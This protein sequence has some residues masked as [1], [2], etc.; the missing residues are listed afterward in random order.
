MNKQHGDNP[1][2]AIIAADRT[3]HAK[4]TGEHLRSASKREPTGWGKAKGTPLQLEHNCV[5][6]RIPLDCV[7]SIK[8]YMSFQDPK[9]SASGFS[10]NQFT[11]VPWGRRMIRGNSQ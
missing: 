11:A 6:S 4:R 7:I 10:G 5:K 8:S 1:R 9:A 3:S 2:H